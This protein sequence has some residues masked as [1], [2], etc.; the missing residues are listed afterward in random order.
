MLGKSG[1]QLR[2]DGLGF[3]GATVRNRQV[4]ND[5]RK[6]AAERREVR[7]LGDQRFSERDEWR[8]RLRRKVCGGREPRDSRQRE[9]ERWRTADHAA[10]ALENGTVNALGRHE[11][12]EHSD[13]RR[14]TQPG[15]LVVALPERTNKWLSLWDANDEP[16]LGHCRS[17]L[18]FDTRG[19]SKLDF[20]FD[21][22]RNVE[23]QLGEADG[24]ARMRASHRTV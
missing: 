3:L 5:G 2:F 9:L 10:D 21:L 4:R 8:W 22:D 17:R 19:G 1:D 24:T 13:V 15:R 11:R 14:H 6:L 7:E 16:G 20:A 23:G 18:T 12:E